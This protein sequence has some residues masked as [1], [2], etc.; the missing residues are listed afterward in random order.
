MGVGSADMELDCMWIKCDAFF[1]DGQG[2]IVAAF[3][4]RNA[5]DIGRTSEGM[6]VKTNYETQSDGARER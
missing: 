5:S 4:V 1:E 3:V 2:F 6:L